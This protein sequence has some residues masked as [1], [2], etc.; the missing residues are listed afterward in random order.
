[1]AKV[2]FAPE[3]EKPNLDERLAQVAQSAAAIDRPIRLRVQPDLYDD[4]EKKYLTWTGLSWS[5]ELE[6]V[7]EGQRLREGLARFFR[8][9]G[10]DAETQAALLEM[11]ATMEPSVG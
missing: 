8:L 10:H 2:S 5:V 6:S 4:A 9:F 7:E 11:L 3:A 1:M